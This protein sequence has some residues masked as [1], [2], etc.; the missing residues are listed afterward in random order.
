MA[1]VLQVWLTGSH[2]GNMEKGHSPRKVGSAHYF[3]AFNLTR[4]KSST[5]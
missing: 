5:S 2:D 4:E 1:V 3:F